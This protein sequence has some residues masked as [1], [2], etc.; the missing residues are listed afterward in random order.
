MLQK[1]KESERSEDIGGTEINVRQKWV[2][3][4]PCDWRNGQVLGGPNTGV[5]FE[6]VT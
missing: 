2:K 5:E 1:V 6:N 3:G 4:E